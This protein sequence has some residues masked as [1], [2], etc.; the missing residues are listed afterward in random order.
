MLCAAYVAENPKSERIQTAARFRI[1][2]FLLRR[3]ITCPSYLTSPGFNLLIW[4]VRDLDINISMILPNF[5]ILCIK[6][7]LIIQ[8]NPF[9][10][11]S[12]DSP[13]TSQKSQTIY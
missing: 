11:V 4:K 9:N 2:V 3:L 13:P 6:G 5:K 7:A 8:K 10:L 1:L 12:G